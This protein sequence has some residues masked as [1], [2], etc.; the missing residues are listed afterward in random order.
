MQKL[1]I[2]VR[3]NEYASRDVNPNLP[4]T[5]EEIGRDAAQVE[6]A[7]ASIIHFHARGPDGSAAHDLATY[8]SSIREIRQH[9]RLLINPTLGQITVGGVESRIAHILA[10]AKDPALRPDLCGIDTGS[11]NIDSFDAP[12]RSFRSSDRVYVNATGTARRFAS[13]F[14]SCGVTPTVAAWSVPFLRM[15]DALIEIGDLPQPTFVL[16]VHCEGGII[17]GHPGTPPGLMAFL[18]AMPRDKRI[19]WTVCCKEG[20]AFALAAMAIALGGHVSIGIGDYHYREI[21]CPTNAELVREVVNMARLV[22]REVATPAEARR[23]L[24]IAQ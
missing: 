23:I 18:D 17:G 9:S 7:G 8:A 11:T 2:E 16:L 5:P 14:R 1:I 19:E 15:A 10:L 22:G 3:A 21:G 20:N 24:G 13:A 4:F 6:A 12:A